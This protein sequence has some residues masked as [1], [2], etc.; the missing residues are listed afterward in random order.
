M[1]I[2]TQELK[3]KIENGEKILIDFYGKFCGPC[4]VMKPWFESVSEEFIQSG[5]EVKLYTYDID[6]DR[7]YVINEIGIR[8]VPTIIG[9]KGGEKVYQNIGVLRK[10]EIIK[11]ANELL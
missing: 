8:S 10:D 4:K 9:F 3:S 1:E 7:E 2:T 5:S 11:V 6:L